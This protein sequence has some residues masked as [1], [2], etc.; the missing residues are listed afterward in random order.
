MNRILATS[1]AGVVALV[2]STF[3]TAA[4]TQSQPS[5]QQEP[6]QQEQVPNQGQSGASVDSQ[7]KPG[8]DNGGQNRD[9]S[10][11][12]KKCNSMS[13]AQKDK[14]IDSARKQHGKL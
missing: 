4:D 6:T 9:Y 8:T 3:A 13:G 7:A 11:A 2:L 5:A 10:A 1:M 14:C 12:L